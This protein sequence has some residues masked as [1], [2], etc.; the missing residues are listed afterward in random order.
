MK[1]EVETEVAAPP[2]IV[3]AALTDVTHWPQFLRAVTRIEVLTPGA[4]AAG[5]TFRE[6]RTMFGRSASEQ[7]TVAALDPPRRFVLTAESHGMRYR[8]IQEIAAAGSGSR[9]RLSFEG[10]P[11]TLAA[12]IGSVLALLFKGAL[13]KQLL[14]DLTDVKAEAER[15]VRG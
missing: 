13:T 14:S 6:T 4:V 10:T 2:E 3:Y 9:L 8:T 1:I 12:K 5:T 11:V 7:M 15:R